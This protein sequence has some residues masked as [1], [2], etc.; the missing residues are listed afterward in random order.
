MQNQA[1]WPTVSTAEYHEKPER[2]GDFEFGGQTIAAGTSLRVDLEV[3]RLPVGV[4]LSLPVV[5]IRGKFA[6][7][8]LF[9]SAAIHG[10]EINGVEVCRN[11]LQTDPKKLHGTLLVIPVVNVFGFV[12]QSR[13]LPDR[14]DLNRSFPGSAKGSLASRLAHLFVNEVMKNSDFGI[15]LHTGSNHRTNVP[16]VRANLADDETRRL[17][18]AFG[19]PVFMHSKIRAGSM[20]SAARKIGI[21]VLLFEAGEPLRFNADAIAVGK[22]GVTRVMTALGMHPRKLARLRH[23]S[24]EIGKHSWLRAPASGM[25]RLT[26]KAGDVV[27]ARQQLGVISDPLGENE[28]RIRSTVG[29]VVIGHTLNPSVN[30]GDGIFHLGQVKTTTG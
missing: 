15:D 10:D 25:L 8:R 30:Q 27:T 5:V 29:G 28:I 14:R 20:R 11:L 26:V 12:D 2:Q 22:R 3:A 16:Q 18:E 21:P 4:P 9:V 23:A 19:A 7:P 6:G 13:Y 17:A 24:E 1:R